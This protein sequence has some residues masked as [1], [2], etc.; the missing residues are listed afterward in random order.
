MSRR[1]GSTG[2][3]FLRIARQRAQAV[4]LY[5]PMITMAPP[6]PSSGVWL[7]AARSSATGFHVWPP[8]SSSR[9]N[10]GGGGSGWTSSGSIRSPDREV[11]SQLEGGDLGLV[12]RPLGPL[13][14]QEPF[15]DVI[16][17][18]LADEVG[19]LHGVERLRQRLRKRH[20]AGGGALL[21]R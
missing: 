12:V 2:M 11:T 20:D 5:S 3:S 18:R 15:E 21:R 7:T 14:A 8:R 19:A 13:V 6:Q 9:A 4:S 1:R 16:A 10:S 17:Q